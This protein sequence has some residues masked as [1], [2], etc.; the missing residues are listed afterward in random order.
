MGGRV[1]FWWVLGCLLSLGCS[2]GAVPE[3]QTGKELIPAEWTVYEDTAPSGEVIT[4]SL[5][6]PAAKDIEGLVEGDAPRLVLRCLD[7]KVVASIDLGIP[8]ISTAP[9]DTLGDSGQ[10]VEI[11][12]D[13]A[14]ACE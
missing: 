14:P 7:G 13:S 2:D 3:P 12:L 6:L 5:Q 4:A 10:Q 11:K 1:R 9:L 8:D